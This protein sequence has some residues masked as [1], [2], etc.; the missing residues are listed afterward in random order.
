MSATNETKAHAAEKCTTVTATA[1]DSEG[2]V[3][4]TARKLPLSIGSLASQTRSGYSA[5]TGS[6]LGYSAATGSKLEGIGI[7]AL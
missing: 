7:G 2:Q 4:K 1:S 6:K 5:A 3:H